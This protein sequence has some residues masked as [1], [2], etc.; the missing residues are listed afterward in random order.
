MVRKGSSVRVRQRASTICRDFRGGGR[1]ERQSSLAQRGRNSRPKLRRVP[2][3][4]YRFH[5][6]LPALNERFSE[7]SVSVP[8]PGVPP[9]APALT[10]RLLAHVNARSMAWDGGGRGAEHFSHVRRRLWRAEGLVLTRQP[11]LAW[12]GRVLLSLSAETAYIGSLSAASDAQM[13]LGQE[14]I[15][16]TLEVAGSSPVAPGR[17]RQR[18]ARSHQ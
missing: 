11:G 12:A 7:A 16:V 5:V 4:G 10:G 13:S 15:S 8:G 2:P 6:A 9:I 18:R 3:S 1:Q 17:L 14:R